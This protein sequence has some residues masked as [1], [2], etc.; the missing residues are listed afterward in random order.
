MSFVGGGV[1]MEAFTEG[2][3]ENIAASKLDTFLS[4]DGWQI[5]GLGELDSSSQRCD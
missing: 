4:L 5:C 1:M 2:L 3:D